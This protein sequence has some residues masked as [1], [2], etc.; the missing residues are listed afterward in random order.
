MWYHITQIFSKRLHDTYAFTITNIISLFF[1]GGRD[2]KGTSSPNMA[3]N[4]TS[5]PQHSFSQGTNDKPKISSPTSPAFKSQTSSTVILLLSLLEVGS[6]TFGVGDAFHRPLL[7]KYT[8]PWKDPSSIESETLKK[9]NNLKKK[10]P[11]PFAVGD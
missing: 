9:S 5:G 11:T 6:F 1:I 2:I 10:V 4:C 3:P 8:K 7:P